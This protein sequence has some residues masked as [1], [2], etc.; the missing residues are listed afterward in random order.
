MNVLAL[1]S[2]GKNIHV[3]YGN[4]RYDYLAVECL[5]FFFLTET[6]SENTYVTVR[7]T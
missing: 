1:K 7:S 3:I 4:S 5:I 2:T 6:P